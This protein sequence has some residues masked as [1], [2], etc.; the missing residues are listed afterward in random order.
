MEIFPP[1]FLWLISRTYAGQA[2]VTLYVITGYV[3][4]DAICVLCLN[5]RFDMKI[6]LLSVALAV[7]GLVVIAGI[8]NLS[9]KFLRAKHVSEKVK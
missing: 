2:L 9:G 3:H 1:L 7:C 5:W 6:T 4:I 8:Y